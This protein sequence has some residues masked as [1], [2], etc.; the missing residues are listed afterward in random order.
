MAVSTSVWKEGK[1]QSFAHFHLQADRKL[2]NVKFNNSAELKMSYKKQ[3]VTK[4]MG[5]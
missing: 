1:F 5:L 4:E 2:P 3:L